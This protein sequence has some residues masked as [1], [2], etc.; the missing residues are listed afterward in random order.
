M[1][2]VDSNGIRFKKCPKCGETK[3]ETLWPF[4]DKEHKT[5]SSYCKSCDSVRKTLSAR[6]RFKDKEKRK[7]ENHRQRLWK[8]G[9]K[10]IDFERMLEKANNSCEICKS[11]SNLVIDH[12]HD[13]NKVRGIL[14]WSCNVALGHFQDSEEKLK[15]AHTYLCNHKNNQ[16]NS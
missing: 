2:S 10:P 12:C 3:D 9:L 16:E 11:E 6:E 7:K 15:K 14:C 8:Y 1:Y 13:T 5:F 4:K